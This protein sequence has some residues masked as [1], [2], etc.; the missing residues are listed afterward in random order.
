MVALATEPVSTACLG[1]EPFR[2]EQPSLRRFNESDQPAVTRADVGEA[3]ITM[4]EANRR[5]AKPASHVG[6][7]ASFCYVM[8]D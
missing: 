5:A 4:S 3:A 7:V 8:T 6:S 2:E 1:H